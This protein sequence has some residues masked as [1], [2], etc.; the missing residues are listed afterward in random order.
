M[1]ASI[2]K[3]GMIM[4]QKYYYVVVVSTLIAVCLP[5]TTV[6]VAEQAHGLE[7]ATAAICRNVAARE[8]VDAGTSFE[9]TVGKL[10]CFTQVTGAQGDTEIYHVWYFVEAERAVVKLQARSSNWRT[11]SSKIIQPNEIGAWRVEVL[12]PEGD[13]LKILRFE[14]TQ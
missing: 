4:K 12:G 9:S 6:S 10:C 7:I 1:K 3:E 2:T 14:I 5:F 8:P 13:V 11:Y